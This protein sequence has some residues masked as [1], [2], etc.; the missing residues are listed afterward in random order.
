MP[1]SPRLALLRDFFDLRD[2]ER[3]FGGD[4]VGDEVGELD[5]LEDLLFLGEGDF[6]AFFFTFFGDC[7]RGESGGDCG[8][9]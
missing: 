9:D 2:L 6:E 4:P 7:D 3:S 5:L 8:G 1:L